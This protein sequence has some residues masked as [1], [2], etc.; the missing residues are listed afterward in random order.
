MK[1]VEPNGERPRESKHILYVQD[2]S[3]EQHQLAT[4]QFRETFSQRNAPTYI[5]RNERHLPM[6]QDFE[7]DGVQE[8]SGF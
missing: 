6:F 7:E 2:I 1:S 8:I 4:H 5:Y 3:R